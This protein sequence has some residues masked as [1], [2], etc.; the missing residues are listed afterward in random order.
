MRGFDGVELNQICG[1]S[2]FIYKLQSLEN[3]C[4][5][6]VKEEAQQGKYDTHAPNSGVA[7]LLVTERQRARKTLSH[8]LHS[9]LRLLIPLRVLSGTVSRSSN[10]ILLQQF[11]P[12][13]ADRIRVW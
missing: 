5:K 13:L 3:M 12:R 7:A 10:T 2:M 8:F 4:R 6:G 11:A 1:V 9:T